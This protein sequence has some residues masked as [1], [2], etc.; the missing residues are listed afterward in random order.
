MDF[1]REEWHHVDSAQ[2]TLYKD[3]MLENYSHLVA[4]GKHHFFQS[5]VCWR[6]PPFSAATVTL[7]AW[8]TKWVQESEFGHLFGI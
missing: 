1:T 5:R 8:V 2:R 3:V 6:V 7:I 4:L